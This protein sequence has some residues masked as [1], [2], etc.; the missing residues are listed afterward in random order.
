[1][2]VDKEPTPAS[3]PELTLSDGI[4]EVTADPDA[5]AKTAQRIADGHGPVAVD[6]ERASGHRYSQRA[7]LVQI[8]RA[9]AGTMLIDPVPFGP[10]PNDTLAALSAAVGEEEWVIH[11]AS[12]DLPCLAELGLR[13]PRL[14]DTELA[15]R[16]LNFPRVG[17]VTLTEE[18]FGVTM[19]KEHSAAD[20]SRRPLPDS[21]LEYAALDVEILVDLRDRL[22]D[23]L[24]EVGKLE[25]ARQEFAAAEVI[26]TQTPD[27]GS[28]RRTSGIHRVRTRRELAVV[29]ALWL[30]RDDIAR[31]LDAPPSRVL[32]DAAIVEAARAQPTTR[33]SLRAVTGFRGRGARPHI[34]DFAHAIAE[35]L[36]LLE[37][38]LPTRSPTYDGPPPARAW[39]RKF[40]EA[41]AR[42]GDCR[43]AVVSL[44]ADLDVPQENLLTPAAVR[45]LAWEPPD[46]VTDEAVA[47]ALTAYGA[48]PW[49]VEHTAAPLA[50]AIR[51]RT[52]GA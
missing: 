34:A 38:D 14:F 37:G 15:G 26:P 16:L 36:G 2:T 13:P 7:Y 43:A 1:M 35:A 49:Q 3:L 44:A 45:R 48:R 32:R 27:R 29:R 12:Q 5:L 20:W 42:L 41:A 46:P 10:V 52:Q 19:R 25:W 11:A 31:R 4:P 39:A 40:P 23:Q 22:R 33:R 18:F 24:A 28:W 21:W 6:A 47:E 17:L 50:A 30:C 51:S 8:R 9:G